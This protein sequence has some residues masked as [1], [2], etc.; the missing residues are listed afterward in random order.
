[1]LV[2]GRRHLDQV[3]ADYV[4]HYNEH[5]PHRSLGQLAPV[6]ISPVS[7]SAS[8]D[9]TRLRRTDKLGGLIHEYKL[10]A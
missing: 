6:S 7:A 8:P 9:A 10:A 1:M 5:R 3:L 2:F 4:A